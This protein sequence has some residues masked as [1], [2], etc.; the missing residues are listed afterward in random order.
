[1]KKA[2]KDNTEKTVE[3]FEREAKARIAARKGKGPKLAQTYDELILASIA[4][5]DAYEKSRPFYEHG[6]H[7]GMDHL[8]SSVLNDPKD[9]LCLWREIAHTPYCELEI[10]PPSKEQQYVIEEATHTLMAVL[11]ALNGSSSKPFLNFFPTD[12]W[13]KESQPELEFF[14]FALLFLAFS[15]SALEIDIALEHYTKW[16]REWENDDF[17][18]HFLTEAETTVETK[19][20]LWAPISKAARDVNTLFYLL[21]CEKLRRLKPIACQTAFVC[22][23]E[24][25]AEVYRLGDS[26]RKALSFPQACGFQIALPISWLPVQAAWTTLFDFERTILGYVRRARIEC[27][28]YPNAQRKWIE[29]EAELVKHWDIYGAPI[30]PEVADHIVALAN[31][32]AREQWIEARMGKDTTKQ[33]AATDQLLKNQLEFH[34]EIRKFNTEGRKLLK[35]IQANTCCEY[36][37]KNERSAANTKRVE[38]T[39]KRYYERINNGT[40]KRDALT[41]ACKDTVE[42]MGLGDYS[43]IMSLRSAVNRELQASDAH[44]GANIAH[45]NLPNPK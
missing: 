39:L 23:G 43:D 27:V 12:W 20:E 2:K 13:R 25:S 21:D 3:E 37:K 19:K 31:D 29:V 38:Y 15:T 41:P 26:V 34:A 14:I 35:S 17:P 28:N 30:T 1:M 4:V 22:Q 11:C 8:I 18:V 45:V 24:M 33:D 10:C 40:D 7:V 36:T 44:H 9:A 16:E 6:T 42:K 32:A 5:I